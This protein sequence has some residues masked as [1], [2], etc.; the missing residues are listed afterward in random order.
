MT[1]T[2][3]A[4]LLAQLFRLDG[5]VALV[6]GG[7]GG[8]GGEIAR[9]LAAVGAKVAV[10]GRSAEKAGSFA[11]ELKAGG[12]EAYG[13][14]FDV[15]SVDEVQRMVDEV[16]GNFGRLDILINCVGLNKEE[17]AEEVTEANFDYVYNVNLKGAMFLAQTAARH[18]IRQGQG[19]KQVHIGSV[20]SLLGLR[21]RGYAAYTATKGGLVIMCKQLA[22]EWA[23]HNINV[24]VVAPTFVR[25]ELVAHML[26]DEKFY[27]GLVSRIPL[28][29]IADVRDVMS[30][31]LFFA[32]PASDFVTGQTLYIDG[33]ITASQ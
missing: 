29:R 16:A 1:T 24:N 15:T 6:A 5:K 30:A 31:T 10:S 33:G 4:D 27:N 14:A 9:G 21:G 18:M 28:G 2:Q 25:T 3:T 26:A 17:K 12:Y 19:G 32:S 13:T 8:I 20:R 23:P 7:Y 11:D 22:M